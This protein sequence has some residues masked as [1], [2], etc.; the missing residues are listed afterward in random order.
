MTVTGTLP[1][2]RRDEPRDRLGPFRPTVRVPAAAAPW[3]V[4]L[5]SRPPAPAR[6]V[7]R[8]PDAVYL[9]VGGRC[10]G[11]LTRGATLVPCGVRTSTSTLPPVAA[12]SDL[13]VGDGFVELP[14]VRVDVVGTVDTRVGRLSPDGVRRAAARARE[15]LTR[16][17]ARLAVVRR[18]LSGEALRDLAAA[19]PASVARLLGAGPG[20]TPLGDDVLSGWLVTAAATDHAAAD[21]V[22]EA[23]RAQGSRTTLLS[24]TLLGCAADGEALPEV[25]D[26]VHA[27][28]GLRPG[29]VDRA[30][31]RLLSVGGTSGAGL[32]VGCLLAL[33]HA[34]AA[35]ESAG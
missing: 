33:T 2:P 15:L 16:A 31:D 26:L 25:R 27:S 19:E 28:G 34:G 13:L 6:V 1:A 21:G 10:V 14:G 20:L 18:E 11:V 24:A 17:D 9:D 35:P 22:R 32:A 4:E 23:V 12:G 8:G 29:R 3:L 7:H 30:F 5:V